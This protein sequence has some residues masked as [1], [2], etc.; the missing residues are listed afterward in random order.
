MFILAIICAIVWLGPALKNGSDIKKNQPSKHQ[1]HT[2]KERLSQNHPHRVNRRSRAP[3]HHL[4]NLRIYIPAY[5]RDSVY[6][7]ARRSSR[8]R[9]ECVTNSLTL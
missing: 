5:R 7:V 2:H 1:N 3:R 8:R 4:A 6:P 9:G